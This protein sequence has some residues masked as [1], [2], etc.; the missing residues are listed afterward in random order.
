MDLLE[1]ILWLAL[2]KTETLIWSNT[3]AMLL[4]KQGHVKLIFRSE[5]LLE[6]RIDFETCTIFLKDLLNFVDFFFINCTYFKRKYYRVKPQMHIEADSRRPGAR[7]GAPLD[8]FAILP[9]MGVR[10]L[11]NS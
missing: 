2:S 4:A 3:R 11:T 5:Q 7:R 1:N 10:F 9:N 8:I 6:Y